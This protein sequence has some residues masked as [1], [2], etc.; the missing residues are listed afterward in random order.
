M[1]DWPLRPYGSKQPNYAAWWDN[2]AL[3][4]FNTNTPAVREFICDVARYWI[5]F[6]IDGWRLDVPQEIDD[7]EFWREFRRVVKAANPEAYIVGEIW[8]DAERWLQGDQYD[9]V[10]NYGVSRAALGF[11]GRETFDRE[12]RPAGSGSCPSARAPSPTRSSG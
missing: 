5:E 6:G 4:K 7:D 2:P 12:Y 3:P 10:M 8:G 1:H 11:F 9:A